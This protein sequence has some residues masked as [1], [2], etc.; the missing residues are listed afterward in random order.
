MHV[1]EEHRDALDPLIV[2][3]GWAPDSSFVERH[4]WQGTGDPAAYLAIPAAIRFLD[5]HDWPTVRRRC[6]ELLE[7]HL[8]GLGSPI[9]APELYV[10][11]AAVELPACDPD[12]VERRLRE[13]HAIEVPVKEWKGRPLLRVSVQ[14]YNTEE[15]L[16]QLAAALPRVL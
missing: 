10:Q 15:D 9:A 6:H 16:E 1:R 4:R 7:Q 5:E 12:E 2:S 13:E 11:M 3:W 8:D 14:A